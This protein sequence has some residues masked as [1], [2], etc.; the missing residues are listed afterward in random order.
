MRNLLRVVMVL[1]LA[2]LASASY[3]GSR[4]TV[5]PSAGETAV[6]EVMRAEMNPPKMSGVVPPEDRKS[7][8]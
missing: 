5:I 8:V 3:Y 7:V 2:L 4:P 1:A 6:F